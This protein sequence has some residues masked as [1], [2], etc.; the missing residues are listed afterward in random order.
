MEVHCNRKHPGQFNI[1]ALIKKLITEC[2]FNNSKRNVFA[3]QANTSNQSNLVNPS[4]QPYDVM[5][6]IDNTSSLDFILS[7]LEQTNEV[8]II[9]QMIKKLSTAY[10]L[11]GKIISGNNFKSM[12]IDIS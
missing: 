4:M 3:N 6:Q 11:N 1:F 10:E 8:E 7:Q 9:M 5:Q 12:I 2:N